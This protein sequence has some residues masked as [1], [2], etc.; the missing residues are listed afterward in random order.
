[1]SIT[2]EPVLFGAGAMMPTN[3]IFYIS[4][5]LFALQAFDGEKCDIWACGTMLFI[6]LTG[7][8]VYSQPSVDDARFRLVAGGQLVKLLSDWGFAELLSDPAKGE[9]L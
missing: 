9:K 7:S 3:K 8:P 1:M 6:M 2:D 4:P 5:E